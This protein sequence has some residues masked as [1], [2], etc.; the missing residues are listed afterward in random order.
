MFV[1]VNYSGFF[2]LCLGLLSVFYDF[3]KVFT[4]DIDC[5]HNQKKNEKR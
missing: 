4:K 3:F 2:I 5:H 1:V